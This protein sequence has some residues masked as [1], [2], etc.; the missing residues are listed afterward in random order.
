MADYKVT[1]YNPT[2]CTTDVYRTRTESVELL[3]AFLDVFR[4]GGVK[5]LNWEEIR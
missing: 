1:M 5:V 4:A 3:E 2:T